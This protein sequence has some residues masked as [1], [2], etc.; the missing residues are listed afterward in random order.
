MFTT[1]ASIKLKTILILDI[2]SRKAI[3]NY[4]STEEEKKIKKNCK[5]HPAPSSSF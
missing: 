3:I 4:R 2:W 1:I 5:D